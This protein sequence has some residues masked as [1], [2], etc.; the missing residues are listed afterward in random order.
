VIYNN[1]IRIRSGMNMIISIDRYGR[2]SVNETRS[3]NGYGRTI[4]TGAMGNENDR[5]YGNDRNYPGE[6]TMTTKEIGTGS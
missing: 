6:G 5:R 4:V 1:S 2:V 3:G